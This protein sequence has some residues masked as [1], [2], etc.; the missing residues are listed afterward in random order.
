MRRASRSDRGAALVEFALIVPLL[1]I[2]LFGIVQFGIVYD[3]QQ[4][5]NSA[6]REGA[7]IGAVKE[8]LIAEVNTR[9]KETYRNTA[10]PGVDPVV[11]VLGGITAK[12]TATPPVVASKTPVA[13]GKGPCGSTSPK[14][15][16]VRVEVT[17]PHDITIPFL[18]VRKV[19][20]HSEA[21]FRC[22]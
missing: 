20:V 18:G 10:S 22:E 1:S 5:M 17:T 11:L 16:Y 7:R 6:A 8:T 12:P 4:S 15:D 21:E 9:A 19:N 14:Y 2:F 13:S 3:K